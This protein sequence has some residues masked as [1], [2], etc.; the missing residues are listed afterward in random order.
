MLPQIYTVT[1]NSIFTEIDAIEY[2]ML[3]MISE[4]TQLFILYNNGKRYFVD[5]FIIDLFLHFLNFIKYNLYSKKVF[6]LP[7]RNPRNHTK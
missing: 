5:M 1:P 6:L 7:F 4:F 3:E 2:S